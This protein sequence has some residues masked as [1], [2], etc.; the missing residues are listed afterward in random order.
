MKI[1]CLQYDPELGKIEQNI[2]RAE[3]L[4]EA[5]SLSGL[6]LLV[7][8]ELALTGISPGAREHHGLVLE[9]SSPC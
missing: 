2:E 7:L 5:S 3:A 1:A 9:V 4:L 8:P 6:D